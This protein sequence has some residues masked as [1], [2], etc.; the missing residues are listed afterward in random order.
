MNF[1]YLHQNVDILGAPVPT[2]YKKGRFHFVG[3]PPG[4]DRGPGSVLLEADV[5]VGLLC[6]SHDD[7][8]SFGNELKRDEKNGDVRCESR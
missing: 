2:T 6:S 4:G 5:F 3:S 1:H 8:F 7:F